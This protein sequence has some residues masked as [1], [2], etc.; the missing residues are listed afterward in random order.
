MNTDTGDFIDGLN[1]VYVKWFLIKVKH[2]SLKKLRKPWISTGILTSIKTKSRYFNLF[3]LGII[4]DLTNRRY[5]NCLNSVIRN[6]KKNYY[7]KTFNSCQNN[8]KKTWCL[9]NQLLSKKSEASSGRSIVVDYDEIS[10][11]YEI[12]EQINK[13]FA[14]IDLDNKLNTSNQNPYIA[15]RENNLASIFFL[16]VT[17]N[18]IKNTILNLRNTSKNCTKFL[19]SY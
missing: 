12:A 11:T 19:C 16:P 7:I 5:R 3:K 10:S 6:A 9:V 17:A 1:A 15:V 18:E 14:N 2:I 8:T 13:H 4:V